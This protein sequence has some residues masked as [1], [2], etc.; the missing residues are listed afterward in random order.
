MTDTISPHDVVSAFADVAEQ[1]R[2]VDAYL[3]TLLGTGYVTHRLNTHCDRV[4]DTNSERAIRHSAAC[5]ALALSEDIAQ[6]VAT[7]GQQTLDTDKQPEL[8]IAHLSALCAALEVVIGS[9]SQ[10]AAA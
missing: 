4:L 5:D 6:V 2:E 9:L 3:R 10:E 1:R 8:A 7:Y